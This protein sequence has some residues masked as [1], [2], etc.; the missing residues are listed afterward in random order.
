MNDGKVRSLRPQAN[1]DLEAVLR[2]GTALP[3]SRSYRERVT[4][5]WE[6]G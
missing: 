1:G 3:V 2:D 5:K 6:R 4:T